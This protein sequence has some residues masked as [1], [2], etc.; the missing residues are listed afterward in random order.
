MCE[1]EPCGVFQTCID[2]DEGFACRCSDGFLQNDTVTTALV[3]YDIDECAANSSLCGAL[4]TCR[5][6]S[7]ESWH[8]TSQSHPVPLKV[9]GSFFCPCTAGY[10]R[11]PDAVKTSDC[12]DTDECARNACGANADC[13]NSVGSYTCRCQKGFVLRD[14]QC[15]DVDEVRPWHQCGVAN[16]LTFPHVCLVVPL[17][18]SPLQHWRHVHQQRW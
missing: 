10:S 16:P 2:L 7:L 5:N 3:C 18:R 8:D 4:S 1:L 6:V 13:T 9:P 11:G 15:Q 12:S 17:G 14:S